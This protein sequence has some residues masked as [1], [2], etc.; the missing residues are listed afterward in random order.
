MR[1]GY[2]LRES[3]KRGSQKIDIF[4]Y[5]LF[6]I[7]KEWTRDKAEDRKFNDWDFY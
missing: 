7:I 5:L 6:P 3:Q 4:G 2:Y 1:V